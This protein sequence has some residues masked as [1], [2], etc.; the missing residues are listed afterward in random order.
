MSLGPVM[1][2]LVGLELS[3]EE[4]E[5]LAHPL[6]GGVILFSRNYRSPRQLLKLVHSVHAIR[7]PPLLV[8][9]DHE[10]G[11]VQRF[12]ESFT[13]IPPAVRF[14]ELYDRQP[15]QAGRFAEQ[16]GW[17]IAVEL[18][19]VKVDF[20]FAPVLDLV[21]AASTVI[22]DRAFHR[23]PEVV[24][25][26]G[27]CFVRGL[28]RGGMT[29]VGKHFP[30]HG[31]VRGDSHLALPVDPRPLATIRRHDL[32]PFE[33]L[34]RHGLA[35]ILPAHVR[36]A[37]VDHRPAGFSPVWLRALL[38]QE[39]GFSGV[40]FSDDLNMAGAAVIGDFVARARAALEAGCDVVLVCN[41]R[42]GAE[43]IL[44]G[45]GARADPVTGARLARMHGQGTGD[46]EGLSASSFYRRVASALAAMDRMPELD[47]Q[48]DAPA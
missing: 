47:L 11:R 35:A 42:A 32:V 41:N 14:G 21:G 13:R 10:G 23:N 17:L 37:A 31:T 6:V 34:I 45:L 25:E 15:G 29:A 44:D 22:G 36:Y 40:V 7:E 9:V 46:W 28:G 48:D 27:R 5:L 16:C 4:R 1:I 8:A 26:L 38:R 3:A 24:A 33:R 39:L 20:T 30:G 43:Q 19:A 2:D 12:R 18:R